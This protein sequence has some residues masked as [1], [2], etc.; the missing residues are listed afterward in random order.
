MNNMKSNGARAQDH[1]KSERSAWQ[2]HDKQQLVKIAAVSPFYPFPPK[3]VLK[4]IYDKLT[5]CT[6]LQILACQCEPD[7]T[8]LP[9]V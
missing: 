2:K 7:S 1:V 5:L 3:F 6:T 9:Y 8:W 4:I